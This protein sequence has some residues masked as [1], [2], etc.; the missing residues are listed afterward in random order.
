ME[1]PADSALLRASLRRDKLALRQALPRAEHGALCARRAGHLAPVLMARPAAHIGFCHPIHNEFD[2]RPLVARLL[3]AGWRASMP[4]AEQ[5]AAPMVFRGWTPQTAMTK[6]HYGIPVPDTELMDGPPDI[7]LL[8]LVAFDGD[9]YRLG[10]G[11]GYFDRTLAACRP[12]PAAIGVGFELGRVDSTYPGRHDFR[13]DAIVTEVGWQ[14]HSAA[15][16]APLTAS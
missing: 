14:S 16:P 15:W 10:Y 8:P 3:A 9:G 7:L 12:P 6:G 2:A 11:G 1:Q 4:V 13:C 5:A